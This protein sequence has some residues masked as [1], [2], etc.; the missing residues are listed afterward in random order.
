MTDPTQKPNIHWWTTKNRRRLTQTL[1]DRL[2]KS[3]FDTAKIPTEQSQRRTLLPNCKEA[4]HLTW[5]SLD[6]SRR[7]AACRY[8]WARLQLFMAFEVLPILQRFEIQFFHVILADKRWRIPS[9]SATRKCF[10]RPRRKVRAS[11]QRLRDR[12]Y[13]PL[14]VAAYELSGDRVLRGSYAFEPHVHLLIGGVPE[15]ALKRAFHVRLPVSMRGRDKPVKVLP[16]PRSE[17]GNLLGYITKIKA[18]DRVQYMGS[19]GRPNRGSNRMP[20]AHCTEWL[21]CMASMPI[22]QTIQFGGFAEPI[23]SRFIHAEMATI[24]GEMK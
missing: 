23:T 18:Q 11:I 2:P 3:G 14:F 5:S 21:R 8:E 16:V 24:A 7:S 22:A 10:D 13:T 9:S 17:L 20:A 15:Q 4:L 1:L 12:G 19:N 6:W